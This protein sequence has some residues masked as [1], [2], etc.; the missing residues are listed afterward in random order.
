MLYYVI[1]WYLLI[2]YHVPSISDNEV[3]VLQV[4]VD[5][6]DNGS[7]WQTWSS[8]CN[9][10]FYNTITKYLKLYSFKERGYLVPSFRNYNVK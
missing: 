8:T 5:H 10:I 6:L 1:D 9:N 4:S 7:I 3:V 2:L